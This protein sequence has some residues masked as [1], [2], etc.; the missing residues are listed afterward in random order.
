MNKNTEKILKAL[1]EGLSEAGLNEVASLLDE[2]V[3]ER[4]AEEVQTIEAKVKGFLR[5]K[6][7]EMKSVALAELESENETIRNGQMYEAIRS[8]VAADIA[9]DDENGI[10][11][12]LETEVA[13]LKESLN[14]VN[15]KLAHSLKSNSLLE[16]QAVT[17]EGE[18]NELSGL[19]EEEKNKLETP[20]KSSESAVIITNENQNSIPDGAASNGFL[21]EDVIRLSRPLQEYK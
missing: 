1:P 16:N 5:T 6:I 13:E 12:H 17:R 20:F 11:S 15:G 2:I 21:T 14:V 18:I 9:S 8:V 10:V 7:D 19:L 3:E 4:V